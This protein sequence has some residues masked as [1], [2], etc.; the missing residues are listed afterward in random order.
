MKYQL[1][2]E[3]KDIVT[4]FVGFAVGYTVYLTGC[5]HYGLASRKLGTN[6]KPGDWEWFDESRLIPTG[7]KLKG[8]KAPNTSGPEPNAP[9]N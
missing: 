8:Y 4:G 7:K 9:E 3:L 5:N 1:G 6:G 2:E